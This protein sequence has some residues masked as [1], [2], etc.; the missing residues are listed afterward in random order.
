MGRSKGDRTYK[1]KRDYAVRMSVLDVTE[2]SM[3][4]LLEEEKLSS[5]VE[6]C[7][8]L[9]TLKWVPD[10]RLAETTKSGFRIG[11]HSHVRE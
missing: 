7:M 9:K 2:S 6:V 4:M 3:R 5:Q 1:N 10:L 8:R 11:R